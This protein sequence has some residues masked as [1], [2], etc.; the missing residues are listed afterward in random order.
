MS[1]RKLVEDMKQNP[2]RFYRSP[3]DVIR[4]RRFSDIERLEILKA[5]ENA[6]DANAA[7]IQQIQDARSEIERKRSEAETAAEKYRE[8]GHGSVHRK[9]RCK[10]P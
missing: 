8:N 3:N 2:Q 6:T 4:D 7:E 9:A 10:P 5:W 1:K